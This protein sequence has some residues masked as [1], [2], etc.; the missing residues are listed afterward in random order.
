GVGVGVAGGVEERVGADV[1]IGVVAEVGDGVGFAAGVGVGVGLAEGDVG[2]CVGF[3]V[4][5]DGDE[6]SLSAAKAATIPLATIMM[7]NVVTTI[8]VTPDF[9]EVT[10][11]K[12]FLLSVLESNR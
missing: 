10:R 2:V 12:F 6:G 3:G 9:E 7:T 8:L 4:D 1:G 5:K 11:K